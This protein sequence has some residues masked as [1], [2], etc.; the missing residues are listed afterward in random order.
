LQ[1][2]AIDLTKQVPVEW[3]LGFWFF[4]ETFLDPH[5]WDPTCPGNTTQKSDPQTNP[6]VVSYLPYMI[7]VPF[8]CSDAGFLA[9]DYAG[10]ARRGAE[11]ATSKAL[12]NEFWNGTL[13]PGNPSLKSVCGAATANEFHG[14]INPGSA[15]TPARGLE[16]LCRQIAQCAGG[17]RGYLHAPVDLAIRWTNEL[18]VDKDK[19]G[20]LITRARENVIVAG[21]GYDGTGPSGATAPTGEQ[22][23]AFATTG[24]VI[25]RLGE[26]EVIPGEDDMKEALDRATGQVVYRAERTA[27]AVWDTV[28][29]WAVLI[30]LATGS[31]GG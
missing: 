28:G 10:R 6:G 7:E 25:T 21:G 1:F 26:I 12:E 19:N 16:L 2:S 23:Y 22:V 8:Q 5:T 11:A 3:E 29:C 18:W 15:V 17:G 20:R 13:M 4:P 27:S 31:D 9:N 14:V 24:P 30:D